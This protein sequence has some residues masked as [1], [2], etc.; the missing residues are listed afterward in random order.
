MRA[1]IALALSALAILAGLAPLVAS[2]GP[3]PQKALRPLRLSSLA[4]SVAVPVG[5][6][7]GMFAAEGLDVQVTI[8]PS[9]AMQY[10]G[11]SEGTWDMAS[12]GFD[13]VLAWSGREGAEIVAVLQTGDGGP[14]TLFVRPEIRTWDDLRGQRL[15]A[16]AVD[17]SLALVLRRILQTHGLDLDRG[18]YELVAVGGGSLRL[19]SLQRGDTVAAVL[20]AP[21]DTIA[22]DAAGLVRL[23]EHR[24]VLPDFP[25]GVYAVNRAW[26]QTHRDEVVGFVRAWLA[27][28]RWVRANREAAIDLAVATRGMSRQAAAELVEQV[29]AS[30]ALNLAGF[31]SVLDLRTRFGF[32][33]PMG[34]DLA[35]YYDVSYYQ[36]ALGE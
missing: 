10:R 12:G 25:G 16:D 14:I 24:E 29:S 36:A 3:P 7:R 18:D 15:A 8:N 9:S 35:R 21:V 19:A 22:A 11:L 33:L 4:E 2:A 30:G 31:Q 5:V 20:N 26:A 1:H 27:A 17:T 23:A 34:T 28:A 6:A 13:N 32:T